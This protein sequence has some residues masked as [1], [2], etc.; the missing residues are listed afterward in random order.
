MVTKTQNTAVVV[1]P[2]DTTGW[3]YVG[4]FASG[5]RIAIAVIA[6]QFPGKLIAVFPMGACPC[7]VVLQQASVAVR[8]F[9]KELVGLTVYPPVLEGLVVDCFMNP[10]WAPVLW[11]KR[12]LKL[13]PLAK[14]S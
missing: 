5:A 3:D 10:V 4:R 11:A 12:P 2:A 14:L 9:Q 1:V 6:L 13:E 7:V 8:L